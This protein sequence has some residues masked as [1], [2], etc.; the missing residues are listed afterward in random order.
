MARPTKF[1]PE[2]AEQIVSAIRAGA[3]KLSAA[4]AAGVAYDTVNE[5]RKRGEAGGRGS[6]PFAK[7]SEALAQAEAE[8]NV[9]AA[10]ALFS[11][12][13]KDWRAALAFLERRERDTWGE[14]PPFDLDIAIL[15]QAA[16]ERIAHGE[17]PQKICNELLAVLLTE[18]ANKG[19][20]AHHAPK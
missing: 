20:A 7:F 19:E 6:A 12:A 14:L 8:A 1:T 4:Q 18:R 16:L 9:T 17:H 5:W 3:S 10:K 13:G 2:R 11:A 15:P